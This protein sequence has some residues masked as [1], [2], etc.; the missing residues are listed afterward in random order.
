MY[1]SDKA[2]SDV[3]FD[4]IC[5]DLLIC[6]SI[7]KTKRNR[8]QSTHLLC[9]LLLWC[10]VWS[11]LTFDTDRHFHFGEEKRCFLNNFYDSK[12]PFGDDKSW[13]STQGL[14]PWLGTTLLAS[15]QPSSMAMWR[16]YKIH[17]VGRASVFHTATKIC[18]KARVLL[19]LNILKVT[20]VNVT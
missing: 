16:V 13:T 7:C 15:N 6:C 9:W 14:N 8:I 19:W 20:W 2:F 4:L 1:F 5:L 17:F 3:A 11:L 10:Y 12:W 18:T